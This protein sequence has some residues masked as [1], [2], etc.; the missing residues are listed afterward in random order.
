MKRTLRGLLK[1]GHV[2]HREEITW[3]WLETQRIN[4]SIE[5]AWGGAGEGNWLDALE[6]RPD[7]LE[8]INRFKY[9]LDDF[10]ADGVISGCAISF[11]RE[12]PSTLEVT[13]QMGRS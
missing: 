8:S 11:S 4:R 2:K 9:R 5:D 12:L 13:V 10:I 3:I 1:G 7:L 6:G